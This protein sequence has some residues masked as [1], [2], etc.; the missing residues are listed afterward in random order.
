[1]KFDIFRKCP[2]RTT[3]LLKPVMPQ[4]GRTSTSNDI[5][6]QAT[7]HFIIS[8][9][10]CQGYFSPFNMSINQFFKTILYLSPKEVGIQWIPMVIMHIEKKL[11]DEFYLHVDTF[12]Y[13]KISTMA[14][15]RA[16]LSLHRNQLC[17]ITSGSQ[18]V[19]FCLNVIISG[20]K[21]LDTYILN[22][23]KRSENLQAGFNSPNRC[24]TGL[25]F[26]LTD[27][28]HHN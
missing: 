21:T 19:I 20:N 16:F 5:D 15:F 8:P 2:G 11:Y 3:R 27:R 14:S 7:R 1:M 13:K 12:F 22:N 26:F 17:T 6:L 23:W 25:F 18:S 28:F 24:F 9:T 10:I 4:A